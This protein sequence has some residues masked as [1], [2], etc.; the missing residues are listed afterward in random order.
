MIIYVVPDISL[1][2]ATKN[3]SEKIK[4]Y[5]TEN[6]YKTNH[7][8]KIGNKRFLKVNVFLYYTIYTSIY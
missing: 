7:V 2:S 1:I 8:I 4:P 6:Y 5:N 3:S